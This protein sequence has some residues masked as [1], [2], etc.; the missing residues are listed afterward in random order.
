MGAAFALAAGSKLTAQRSSAELELLSPCKLLRK[1][2]CERAEFRTI[3]YDPL[4]ND[5]VKLPLHCLLPVF[6][7]P[8]AALKGDANI[9]DPMIRGGTG[10][11][12]DVNEARRSVAMP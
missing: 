3:C 2:R 12:T 5:I 1:L 9:R 7:V 11:L 6:A 10:W 4:R 8:C